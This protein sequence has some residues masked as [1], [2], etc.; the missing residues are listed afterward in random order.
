MH[1][2]PSLPD[3]S[4]AKVLIVGDV[5]LDR[6]WQG[7]SLRISP[8]APVPVV[9]IEQEEQRIGGAGNVALNASVLGARATLLALVG[10]D[11]AASQVRNLL[12]QKHVR[13]RL[14]AVPGS[15]T[16]TKLRVLSQHQQLIRLD[17][18]DAFAGFNSDSLTAEFIRCLGEVD[19]VVLSDYAKG[20]LRHSQA[21]LSI[22]REAKKPV[23][24]DPKGKD[25]ERYR[26]ATLI[27]PN[28]SEFETVVGPCRS[29]E[30]LYIKGENLRRSLEL[31]AVL[32]TRSEKGMTLLTKDSP[33]FNLP[34]RAQEVFDVTGAGDTVVAT[35]VTAIAAGVPLQDAVALSNIAAGIVVA[36]IG[37]ATVTPTELACAAR[38]GNTA[39]PIHG[40]VSEGELLLE[41]EKARDNG[42]RVVMVDGSF[43]FIH[44]DHIGYLEKVRAI[45]DRLIVAVTYKS[46]SSQ[47][48]R[49]VKANMVAS[50]NCVDWVILVSEVDVVDLYG[51]IAPDAIVVRKVNPHNDKL[52]ATGADVHIIDINETGMTKRLLEQLKVM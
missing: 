1:Y 12:E 37:T 11:E 34:T 15:K 4:S 31:D 38:S 13:C 2:F 33:P 29:E 19:A 45:G 3:F 8:E 44:P 24:V 46:D 39:S 14:Q 42:E 7:P 26:G 52:V 5:M 48:A 47:E 17:F 49:Q 25:F 27:T 51:R 22:A 32:V 20:T 21:L 35:L 40:M 9:K 41:M 43:D 36:K 18:E 6:Y 23:I 28:L 16:I 30:E 10:D 50:L